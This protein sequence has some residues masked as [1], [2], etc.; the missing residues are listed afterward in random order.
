VL[1]VHFP[2]IFADLLA[3]CQ[4]AQVKFATEQHPAGVG[5]VRLDEKLKDGVTS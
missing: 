1:F 3:A 2:L 4:I 5:L